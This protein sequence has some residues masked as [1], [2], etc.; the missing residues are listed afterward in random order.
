MRDKD[1]QL[2]S[3]PA[4]DTL[5]AQRPIQSLL[6]TYSRELVTDTI[7][8]TIDSARKSIL[9]SQPIDLTLGALAAQVKVNLRERLR[10]SLIPVING[11]GVIIHTNLGRAVLSSDAQAAIAQAALAYNNLEYDLEGG[12]RGSRL[13]HAG[14][15]L[16]EL[17]G[18]EDALVVNNNA[19]ALI[20]ILSALAK[21]KE[22]VISRGQLVEIGGGFRIPAIMQ[23]SGARLVEVGTTNRTRLADFTGALN[24]LTAMVLRVHA[25]NFKQVGFVE[26]PP[27]GELVALAR[28]NGILSVDDLGSGTLIDTAPFGLDHEP[29]IQESVAAGFD[30]V[31][32][33]GDKL[34]GGPQAGVIV[35][36]A[37]AVAK[38]KRH[39]LARALRVD[40]LTYAALLA[41]LAHY[42]RG[43]ALECLPVW[44]MIAR[45]LGEIEARA[46]AWAAQIGGSVLPGESAVGGGSLPGAILPTAV[47]AIDCDAPDDMTAKLRQGSPPVIARIAD[48]RVLIDPRTVLPEQEED[49]LRVLNAAL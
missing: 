49:L 20:L 14:R 38:L 9:L 41:T 37:E 40:K 19:S 47:L 22:V 43:D 36:K 4:I 12:R 10:P 6:E 2:R 28:E 48:G 31:C 42:R 39:P 29:M 33:S 1:A 44:R 26:Q 24:E 45:T 13:T 17:T 15:L 8:S 16:R 34:L 35:G 7:R 27:L 23:E 21:D 18:A 25:S 32:F 46:E 11:T 3:L 30:L 5:L